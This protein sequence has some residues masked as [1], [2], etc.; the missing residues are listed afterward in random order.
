MRIRCQV[1]VNAAAETNA[2]EAAPA[3]PDSAV[4]D[5]GS[6]Q[7]VP[8]DKGQGRFEPRD[9][10]LGRR[11]GDYVEISQGISDGEPVVVSASF[12]IDAVVAA[13]ASI[14]HGDDAQMIGPQA[15]HPSNDAQAG[16]DT[17]AGLQY[18]GWTRLD[19]DRNSRSSETYTSRS[20]RNL[21]RESLI[22]R[23]IVEHRQTCQ[24]V[25]FCQERQA[26]C[27]MAALSDGRLRGSSFR[28]RRLR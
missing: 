13:A 19:D 21:S 8:V 17:T 10:K 22:V 16:N 9:V 27:R 7:T 18:I 28:A 3:I 4:L 20:M 15:G 12:L 5:T 2:R 23:N 11:G 26:T 25:R 1:P 14:I 6:K 24:L